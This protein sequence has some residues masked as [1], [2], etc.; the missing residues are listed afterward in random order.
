MGCFNK[1]K[2]HIYDENIVALIVKINVN[3]FSIY[4]TIAHLTG[5][6]NRVF[7]KNSTKR[8]PKSPT[9]KK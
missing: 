2:T 9:N 5:P 7:H 4:N 8:N 3:I 1:K 6:T